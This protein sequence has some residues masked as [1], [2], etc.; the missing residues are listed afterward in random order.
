MA[1]PVAV[2]KTYVPYGHNFFSAPHWRWVIGG[3]C[4]TLFQSFTATLEI[5][6]VSGPELMTLWTWV[7]YPTTWATDSS[8]RWVWL[9]GREGEGLNLFQRYYKLSQCSCP[10]YYPFIVVCLH[11]AKSTTWWLYELFWHLIFSCL[12]LHSSIADPILGLYLCCNG[13]QCG[14]HKFARVYT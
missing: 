11:Y 3:S 4:G 6:P 5:S 2:T 1:V 13:C 9:W 8:Y 14:P 12:A 10:I 7:L